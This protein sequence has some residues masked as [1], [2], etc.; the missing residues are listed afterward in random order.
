MISSGPVICPI[1]MKK[2]VQVWQEIIKLKYSTMS[3]YVDQFV[4]CMAFVNMTWA[5]LPFWCQCQKLNVDWLQIMINN[6]WLCFASCLNLQYHQGQ[7]CT[8][9]H[10][11][12]C[13]RVQISLP[14]FIWLFLCCFK[15]VPLDLNFQGQ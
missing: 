15:L 6:I 3:D 11:Y 7:I 10:I 12:I 1:P 2:L 8:V 13:L 9:A 5:L 14:D 4:C